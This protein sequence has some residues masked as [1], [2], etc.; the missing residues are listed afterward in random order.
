VVD[1][2]GHLLD[3][4]LLREGYRYSRTPR[5]LSSGTRHFVT[6][7]QRA[8]HDGSVPITMVHDVL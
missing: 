4:H 8:A 3:V 5:L 6:A 2:D 7:I 1:V